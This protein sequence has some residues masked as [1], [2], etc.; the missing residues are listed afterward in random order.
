MR[1]SAEDVGLGHSH[2]R[3]KQGVLKKDI[4]VRKLGVLLFMGVHGFQFGTGSIIT[5]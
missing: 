5:L 1:L 2:R 4:G 3:P